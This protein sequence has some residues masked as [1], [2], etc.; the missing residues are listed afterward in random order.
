MRILT[1]SD[2]RL[3]LEFWEL[4][5]Y[6]N[7]YALLYVVFSFCIYVNGLDFSFILFY[8]ATKKTSA[9]NRDFLTVV[10]IVNNIKLPF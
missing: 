7:N 1:F 10:V 4:F 3:F 6:N 2:C 5:M 9:E 8:R